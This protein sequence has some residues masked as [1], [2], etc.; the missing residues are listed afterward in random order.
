MKSIENTQNILFVFV[1]IG[2]QALIASD[3]TDDTSSWKSF[4]TEEKNELQYEP[5]SI[6][7]QHRTAPSILSSSTGS[8]LITQFVS[9]QRLLF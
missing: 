7:S 6:K 2:S 8:L 3:F 4:F 9:S 5:F 1:E